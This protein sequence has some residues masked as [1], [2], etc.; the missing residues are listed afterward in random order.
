MSNQP[1]HR[2]PNITKDNI[3]YL[4]ENYDNARTP[5]MVKHLKMRDEK[6]LW[7]VVAELRKMGV[8]IPMRYNRRFNETL[9][10]AVDDWRKQYYKSKGISVK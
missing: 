2:W 3:D 6:M 7:E 10:S 5:D 4:M 1:R 9:V 8:P